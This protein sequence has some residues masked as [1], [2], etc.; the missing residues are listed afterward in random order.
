MWGSILNGKDLQYPRPTQTDLKIL[1]QTFNESPTC[2]CFVYNSG[3]L[4]VCEKNPNFNQKLLYNVGELL[5]L[6]SK[7]QMCLATPKIT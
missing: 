1:N 5:L 4:S 3:C 7:L 6:F 2:S